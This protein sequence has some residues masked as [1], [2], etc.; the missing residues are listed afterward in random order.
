M[1]T[2]RELFQ[3][4]SLAAA[5][6]ASRLAARQLQAIGVQLYTV[7]SVLPQR[8][9]ETL[10]AIEA[11][12]YR[13]IEPTY[14]GLDRIWPAIQGTR[15]KPVSV[16][17]DNTLMNAGKENDLA[18]AIEQVKK[19]GFAYA[20]FPYV[21]PA[22]RGGL[23]KFRVLSDKLNK[24][25]EKCRAAG[26]SFCYHNH[27]F[28]FEPMEGTTGFQVMMDRLDKNLCGFEVDCFWVS[29]A[30][31]DPAQ[32]LEKLSGRVPLLHLKD[33]ASGTPVMY[34]ESVDRGAF[35]EVGHGVLDWPVILR[36]AA[37]AGVQH[38]FVEQDQTPGDPVESLRQSFR[39]LSTLHY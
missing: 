14:G 27:A 25:G 13:E 34:K 5:L 11:I 36:A 12:G 32:L 29:V 38:Y 20:V 39:Y 30:G 26:L 2:R 31:H 4:V 19:W 9:T 37:S 8:P 24:A 17:L 1:L 35:K 6:P 23:D 33:K 21:P 10:N 16:H 15:L 7:R 22:E 18:R 3:S 28:E